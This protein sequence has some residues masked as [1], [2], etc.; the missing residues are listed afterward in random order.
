MKDLLYD[1][2]DIAAIINSMDMGIWE[3][4][5]LL[6]KVW[7]YDRM[8]LKQEYRHNQKKLIMNSHYWMSY[9]YEKSSIDA[10]FPIVQKD[11]KT[12]G[13][14]LIIENFIADY[15][16]I[17]LFFKSLRYKILYLGKQDYTRLK[18]RT[19]LQAYGY[20]RHSKNLIDYMHECLLFYHIQTYERG[21]IECD[22]AT[23]DLDTM[24]TF[25]VV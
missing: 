11:L 16:C 19:I 1:A 14:D 5:D 13:S 3:V 2:Y 9:L 24:I 10:E 8:Y 7:E 15:S 21:G 22:V 17:N 20:K 25:R 12:L 18:L 23:V 6:K 4:S